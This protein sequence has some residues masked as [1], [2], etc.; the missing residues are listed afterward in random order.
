MRTVLGF[1]LL[2][3]WM[4]VVPTASAQMSPTPATEP[5]PAAD[6]SISEFQQFDPLKANK[7]IEVGTFY[8]KKGNY[9]AA[10]ERFE[11]AARLQPGLARPYL[12]LGETYEKIKNLPMAVKSYKKY[13][14]LYP[15]AADAKSVRKRIAELEKHVAQETA[16]PH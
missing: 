12:K 6:G 10:I 1:L 5:A 11:E 16:T 2:I 3:V 7:D 14:E 8:F 13:L 9:D 4:A 15:A